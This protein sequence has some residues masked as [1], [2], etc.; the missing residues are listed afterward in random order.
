MKKINDLLKILLLPSMLITTITSNS[1]TEKTVID[2]HQL[3]V[4]G[5]SLS[6]TGSFCWSLGVTLCKN[7]H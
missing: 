6:D 1:K 4:L 5:D 3:Y 2:Y 7:H